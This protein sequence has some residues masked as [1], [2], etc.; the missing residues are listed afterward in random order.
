MDSFDDAWVDGNRGVAGI[1]LWGAPVTE[2]ESLINGNLVL[3]HVIPAERGELPDT[4]PSV[5]SHE[6]H[7]GIGFWDQCKEFVEL[8]R[9]EVF[10]M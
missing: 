8:R 6:N 7:R 5:D 1:A 3:V 10:R 9:S 4:E 2:A